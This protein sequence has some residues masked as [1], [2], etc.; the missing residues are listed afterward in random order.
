MATEKTVT[1]GVIWAEKDKDARIPYSFKLTDLLPAGVPLDS[2][3]VTVLPV[4]ALTVIATVAGQTVILDVSGG[5]ERDWASIRVHWVAGQKEDDFVFRVFTKEDAEDVVALGSQLFPNRFTAV[6]A[7]RRDQLLA[8][9]GAL[10]VSDDYVWMKLLAAEAE[11]G[12]LLRVPLSPT[13]F[14]TKEPTAAQITALGGQ[15]W[16]VD[17]GY[18]YDNDF[19][20]SDRW[21]FLRLRNKPLISVS[22]VVIRFPGA[23]ATTFFTIPPDWLR[24]DAKYADVQFIPTSTDGS[25]PLHAFMLQA[26]S[27]GRGIPFAVNVEYVAGLSNVER[28]YPDLIDVVRKMAV[29]STLEDAFQPQSGSLSADGLSQSISMDMEKHRDTV[30]ARLYG[31]KG[32]NGGLFTALN[33]IR[34][35]HL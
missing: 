35:G 12:H 9:V 33:G 30:H 23:P 31:P 11:V 26:M 15:R 5:I 28:N 22:S 2:C 24:F 7:L 14:F 34:V 10:D 1:G 3:T 19:F 27:V 25:L 32:S 8:S 4:G 17:P 6:A 18:D 21:G 20:Q 29:L 13:R 16:G